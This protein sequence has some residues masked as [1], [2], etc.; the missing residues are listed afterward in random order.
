MGWENLDFTKCSIG[1]IGSKWQLKSGIIPIFQQIF[2]NLD[3]NLKTKTLCGCIIW[4]ADWFRWSLAA[5]ECQ[6]SA[7]DHIKNSSWNVIKLLLQTYSKSWPRLNSHIQRM[8]HSVQS[9]KILAYYVGHHAPLAIFGFSFSIISSK[10][11]Y[12]LK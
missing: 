2:S 5:L 3:S 10:L 12:L 8:L 1:G 7:H 9:V 6:F 11:N 4:N